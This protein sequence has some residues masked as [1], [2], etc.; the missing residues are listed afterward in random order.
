MGLE[1]RLNPHQFAAYSLAILWALFVSDY[2]REILNHSSDVKSEAEALMVF[3]IWTLFVWRLSEKYSTGWSI[4]VFA[5][6]LI[7][8]APFADSVDSMFGGILGLR[9]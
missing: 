3:C 5:F 7:I 2:V 9:K 8:Y 4:Y 6:A 1:Y